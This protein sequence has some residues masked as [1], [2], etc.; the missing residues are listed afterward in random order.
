MAITQAICNSF[1]KEMLDGIHNFASGGDTFKIALFSNTGSNLD[2]TTTTYTG[3]PGEVS[4][5][6]YTT[7][8]NTLTGQATA[9]SAGTSYVDFND[10]SWS[11]ST[12]TARGALIYNSS[13]SNRA[14]IVLNFGTDK[15]SNN[16]T[17]TILFPSADATNA[18]IRIS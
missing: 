4:G 13:K 1:K 14:V 9:Q 3:Q 18:I 10:T 7:G 8:G 12:I 6:G 17:F 15:V 11:S 2:A 16:S 5:A